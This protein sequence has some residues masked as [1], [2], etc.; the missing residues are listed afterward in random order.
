MNHLQ[1][2]VK[3]PWLSREPLRQVQGRR[4]KVYV[5]RL[6]KNFY[7]INL[8]GRR[9]SHAVKISLLQDGI[10]MGWKK[11]AEEWPRDVYHLEIGLLLLTHSQR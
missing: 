3:L 11:G 5:E 2:E 1:V 4:L 8:G 6:D 9:L 7:L 10:T